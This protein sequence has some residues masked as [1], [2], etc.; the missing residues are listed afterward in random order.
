MNKVSLFSKFLKINL[1]NFKKILFWVYFLFFIVLASATPF[2]Y[3]FLIGVMVAFLLSYLL[4]F[5]TYK[6]LDLIDK[7][8]FV[9]FRV[10]LYILM[11]FLILMYLYLG[12]YI[13][14]LK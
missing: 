13:L 4:T 1:K 7:R 10:L 5:L 14:S 2:F 12:M 8:S 6:F 3:K 9:L 11:I